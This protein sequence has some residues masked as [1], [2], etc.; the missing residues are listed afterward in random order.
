MPNV[1]VIG[2][3][4]ADLFF[5]TQRFPVPG[6][7]LIGDTFMQHY[8]GKGA[9]QAVAAAHAAEG[10][11]VAMIGAVGQDRYGAG[12]IE[13]LSEAGVDTGSVATVA[14]ASTAVA[15]IMVQADGEN[16]IIVIPGASTTVNAEAAAAG[17]ERIG[18]QAGD[19]VVTVLEIP[20]SATEAACEVARKAGASVI[21][22]PAPAP[23]EPAALAAFSALVEKYADII[24]L[25]L[26][27]V[28]IKDLTAAGA[29]VGLAA[30]VVTRGS[31]GAAYYAPGAPEPEIEQ[32]AYLG[33][34]G[35][36]DT[37]GAGDCFAGTYAVA[38]A[39]GRSRAAALQRAAAA[40]GLSVGVSG[41]MRS[42][43][44][45]AEIKLMLD[46]AK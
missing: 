12:A 31:R 16:K 38:M 8:G 34:N 36:V 32:R 18:V 39:G 26:N 44:C 46:Q 13:A 11:S 6:E 4:N 24:T 22:T 20:I 3:I 41:T 28:E 37:T 35:V 21:L 23:S 27:E 15:S 45:A 19:V 17:L 2:S 25:M 7:T 40:A 10:Q 9:N 14:D 42:Y 5:F 30:R 43:P 29:P 33:S 1:I